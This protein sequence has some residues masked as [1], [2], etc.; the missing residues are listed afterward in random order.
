MMTRM[1]SPSYAGTVLIT[2]VT[3]TSLF[4]PVANAADFAP[5]QTAIVPHT[6]GLDQSENFNRMNRQPDVQLLE[7]R[8]QACLETD[9]EL[10]LFLRVFHV[11]KYAIEPVATPPKRRWISTA[12]SARDSRGT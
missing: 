7:T 4:L 3:L 6:S 1:T 2:L 12:A 8:L 10:P 5:T 9:E 11:N